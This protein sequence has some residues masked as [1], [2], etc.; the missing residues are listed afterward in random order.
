VNVVK[1]VFVPALI[2]IAWLVI[3]QKAF[4]H[5][6]NLVVIGFAAAVYFLPALIGRSKR[7]ATAIFMLNLFLGWTL[8]GWVVALV[9]AT[10]RD[11]EQPT[12]LLV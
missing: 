2:G 12:T 10:T 4:D 5:V 11:A 6:G 3:D 1:W 8:I 9:W 7:N